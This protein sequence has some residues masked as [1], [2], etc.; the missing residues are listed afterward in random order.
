MRSVSPSFAVL[1]VSGLLLGGCGSS[2]GT[3]SIQ[4]PG[5]GSCAAP[6]PVEAQDY[7]LTVDVPSDFDASA[8]P[9]PTPTTQI[10]FSVLL[11]ERCPGQSFPLVLQSHGYSGTRETAVGPDGTL[12]PTEPHFPSIN[13]LVRALPHHGYVVISYDERGHGTPV[14]GQAPHNARIIDPA[15]EIQDAIAL[16]DWAYDNPA[17]SFAQQEIGTGISKD[18]RVGTIGYSYGGGFEMPLA[19][20]DA[21]V[22]TIVPNGTWHNLLYSLLPGDGLK[23]GF[24]SLLCTLALQGNV[25]NTPLVANLCN[26]VGPTGPAAVTLRTRADLITAASAPIAL[27]RPAADSDELTNF[28][29]THGTGYFE[30]AARDGKAIAERDRPA[31]TLPNTRRAIPALFVQGNR[32]TL[33]N[34]TDAYRNYAYFK[35]AGADVRLLSTEGGHMNPLAQ[36]MEGTANCGGVVGVDAMLAWFDQKLKGLD[37][38]TYDAIPAVCISVTPTPAAGAAP[39]NDA[40]TGVQLTD[41]PVGSLSGTG[42]VPAIATSLSASVALGSGPVFQ[43]VATIG[44]AQAGAVLAGVP[45]VQRVSVTAGTGTLVTPVAYVGVGIQRGETLI[46]VDDEITPFAA[47]APDSGTS[48]C[49]SGPVTD[50]CRNRGTSND[51]V[52][53]PGVGELL[54]VGD[55]VGLLFYENQVQYLP[56]NTAG[57]VG[58]PNPYN[59]TMTDVE[60]PILLPCPR[61]AGCYAGS[62]LSTP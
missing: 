8:S 14:P 46:L 41:V 22:D 7:V 58:L 18:L 50:H 10:A 57:V 13:T 20:L 42:A 32:D 21:R 24:G 52:L 11:P 40:L 43:P 3:G 55:Q 15:A 30:T 44:E 59:V 23:L 4:V 16:L 1:T 56:V 60:L 61:A 39:T 36:Q 9:T 26:L 5:P 48:D 19:L 38:A 49:A 27:P 51:T 35:A 54:Q 28:F 33:F 53:L 25:N 12:D 34:L 47:L 29:Y 6:L 45:R 37:S 62:R 31:I 17:L 2:S